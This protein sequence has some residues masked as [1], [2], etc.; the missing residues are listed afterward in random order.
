MQLGHVETETISFS[1]V[2]SNKH[3]YVP[4]SEMAKAITIWPLNSYN[5]KI[6]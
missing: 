3:T 6:F 1:K 2:L 4:I 5:D